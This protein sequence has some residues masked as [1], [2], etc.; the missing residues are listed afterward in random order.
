MKNILIRSLCIVGLILT[1]SCK[2]ESNQT[3]ISVNDTIIQFKEIPFDIDSQQN[4]LSFVNNTQ[5]TL[6]ASTD[7]IKSQIKTI[8]NSPSQRIFLVNESDGFYEVN[9]FLYGNNPLSYNGF[10]KKEHF[11]MKSESSL[12]SVDLNAIRY[13][14][15][16]GVY[17]DQLK[18]FEKYGTVKLIS[19][20][21]YLQ[22]RRKGNTTFIFST[23]NIEEN[24]QM[25]IY[26]FRTN[27]GEQVEIPMKSIDEETGLESI[28]ISLGFSP[29]LQSYV[30]RVNEDNE[31]LYSFYSKRNA[32]EEVQYKNT[33]PVYHKESQQF[34]ELINDNDVGCLL[35]ISGL[36]N[37]F[38]FKEKLLVN[39]VNF[40]MVPNTLYWI[41]E[42]SVI[43][44]AV[45]TNQT[46][47][48]SRSE[49]LLIEFNL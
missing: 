35:V 21:S 29:I 3:N 24:K 11:K 42:K 19:K 13:S 25:G 7:T 2:K 18:S 43:V 39:F 33:L 49:Y 34:A 41:N 47:D 23:Q 17:N 14:N 9:Y 36:D 31:T 44:E 16:N 32:Q 27:S 30:F 38:R 1:I 10:V 40:K 5:V 12:E 20:Q 4:E 28:V 26:S 37:N 48:T 6:F 45:H 15:L 22:N 46:E 8:E